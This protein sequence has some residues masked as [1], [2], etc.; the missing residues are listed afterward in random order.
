M[1]AQPC[2]VERALDLECELSV[3]VA[4]DPDGKSVAYPAARNHH[5]NGIL[6]WSVLPGGFE[7]ALEQ[8]ARRVA[9]ALAVELEL[10]G[11]LCVELFLT[12]DGR[13][14]VNELAPRPHNSYHASIEACATSQFEQVVRAVCGWPL[15]S[16][17][18][19]RPAA[20]VN[21][22]GD[23][24]SDGRAPRFERALERPGVRLHL[25]GKGEPR[26]ARKMGHLSALG[27]TGDEARRAVLE[28]YAAL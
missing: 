6:V 10:V 16:T 18:V 22:L 21:L 4:R 23:L 17:E 27:A 13:L 26:P 24:W 12:T 20:I 3:L 11:L 1:G 25:Y 9:L 28:A 5:E 8:E 14:F 15:G 2:V 19:V 7:P